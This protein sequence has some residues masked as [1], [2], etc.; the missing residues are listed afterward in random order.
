MAHPKRSHIVIGN[1]AAGIEVGETF[2]NKAPLVIRQ[3]IYAIAHIGDLLKHLGGVRLPICRQSPHLLD[4]LFKHF[5]HIC[6]LSLSVRKSIDILLSVDA[7]QV[8]AG[9]DR[10]YRALT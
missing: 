6:T 3:L 1:D 5:D 9:H 8:M 4:G 10:L 2:S 7:D